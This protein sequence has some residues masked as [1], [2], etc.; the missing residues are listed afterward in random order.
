MA[1]CPNKNTAEYKALQ[2]VYKTELQTNNIINSW[3]DANNVDTFPTTVEAADYLR[4]KKL[5]FNLKQRSFSESILNNLRRERIIHQ[6]Q[7]K[8]Y[9][10]NSNPNTR[11]YDELILDTNKRKLE[12]Y[13]EIN[14]IPADRISLQRTPKSYKVNVNSDMFSEKDVLERSRSWDTPRARAVV[15]H[16][17][18][19]FPQISIEMLS[20]GEASAL[21]D[22]MPDWKKSNTPFDKINSFYVDGTAYLIKGRVTDETAIEEMLHPFVDAIAK[23]NVELFD[24]LLIEAVKNFPVMSQEISDSYNSNERN[25]SQMDRDLEIVT[26]ALSRHFNNE[27]ENQPTRSF[28]NVLKEALDWFMNII[29]N[30]NLYLTGRAIP[31][32]AINQNATFSDLARL[33]NTEGIQFKLESRVDGKIRFAL[34]PEKQ[35]VV[36]YAK[37]QA[38]GNPLQLSAINRLFNQ[39]ADPS[40]FEQDQLVV[41]LNDPELESPIVT[42]NEANHTYNNI[43]AGEQYMSATTAIKGTLDNLED[44][45]LNLDLGNDVDAILNAIAGGK[46]FSDVSGMKVLKTEEQVEV[47]WNNLTDALKYIVPTNAILLPQVILYDIGTKLAGTA[48]IV[49]VKENG[50]LMILD[51]KTTKNPLNKLSKSAFS[52]AEKAKGRGRVKL[53]DEN[54]KLS[55]D[56]LLKQRGVGA[57][58]TRGQHNLQV[59]MYRRM[60]QNMGYKVDA[61]SFGA[62]TLHFHADIT[63]KGKNQKFNGNITFDEWTQHELDDTPKGNLNKILPISNMLAQEKMAEASQNE[64]QSDF[65]GKNQKQENDP[66]GQSVDPLNYPETE[67]IISA[68]RDYRIGVIEKTKAIQMIKSKVFMNVSKKVKLEELASQQ[69]Y[70]TYALSDE[71]GSVG[72]S[73]IYTNL[74]RDALKQ[75]QEFTTYIEDPNNFGNTEFITSVVNFNRFIKTFEGLYSI[76]D[77][78]ELNNTQLKLIT[79]LQTELNKLGNENNGL[80]NEALMNFIKE[81]IRAR[82]NRD[83]GGKNSGFTEADLE[84]LLVY[85]PDITDLDYLT[86]DMAT[87]PDVILAVMDKIYKGAIQKMLDKISISKT[88]ILEKADKLLKLSPSQDPQVIHNF[89]IEEDGVTHVQKIGT[90]YTQKAQLL[91]DALSDNDGRPYHYADVPNVY[92]ASEDDIAKNIDLADKK[93]AMG[94]FWRA[95]EI[96]EEGNLVDGPLHRYTQAFKDARK[97]HEYSYID[98][99]NGYIVWKQRANTSQADYIQY[100]AKYFNSNENLRA[101]RIGGK[102]TGQTVFNESSFPKTEYREVR[103]DAVIDGQSILNPKYISIMNPTDALGS[104][105]KEYYE[106]W[107]DQYE[108]KLDQLP[109]GQRSNMLGRLPLVQNKLLS[110]AKSKDPFVTRMWAQTVENISMFTQG[111]A[112]QRGISTDELGNVVSTL[113][114]YFVGR[115]RVE[116]DLEKLQAEKI[117]IQDK[118]K[119]NKIKAK[120]YEKEIKL[121]NGKIARLRSTPTASQISRDLT[122]SLLKFSAM[123]QNYETMSTVEDTL[124]AMVKVLENREYGN[125]ETDIETTKSVE[126]VVKKAGQKISSNRLEANAVRRAKKFM[127]MV[128]YDNDKITKGMFDKVA[129]GL[130]QASSLTYVAFNPF[131]NFNNYVIGRVNNGIE[132]LGQRF[133]SRKAYKRA[134]IEFNK[135]A[136]PDLVS[137]TSYYV[138]DLTEVATLGMVKGANKTDYDPT[139]PNSK[140]EAFVDLFRMMDSMTDIREQG[141]DT[142]SGKSWFAKATEWGYVLQDAAEYNVQTKVGMAMLMDT[143]LKNTKEGHPEFGQ[144]LA[145]YDAFTYNSK[146]HKNELREGYDTVIKKNGQEVKYT[147]D[148]RY[149]LR[150]EIREVNKQ[151]HGNYAKEDRMVIQA[152]TLGNLAAQFHKWVMPAFRARYQ[153]EYFDENLGWMEGRYVSAIKFIGYVMKTA[154][155]KQKEFTTYK[156]GFLED[157]GFTGEGGNIDQRAT[158]KLFGFYRTA[159]EIGIIISVFLLSELMQVMLAGDDDDSE[160]TKRFKNILKYQADRTYKE[161]ILFTPHPSGLKQQYQM[162]KSPIAATRTLGEVGEALSLSFRTPIA[163]AYYSDKEFRENSAYVY[164]TK[165]RKGELKLAKNWKDVIPI[166]Y[167]IQKWDSYL[168]MSDFFIK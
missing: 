68:L 40:T 168:K 35:S 57:L 16:L 2:A 91:R 65:S 70:L 30:L 47:I 150:N 141:A 93:K 43:T 139:K 83:F 4:N 160:L 56:S 45:Q 147:D 50:D 32:N 7:D 79:T 29:E 108:Q 158:N 131:G 122:D 95:E 72:R 88:I 37:Q 80:V 96:D 20:V 75:I 97:L 39:T 44:V 149:Q 109:P 123:A 67:T 81:Q 114:V 8:Y 73:T 53:Y 1:R 36:D 140:Y 135:R 142:S 78:A 5:A 99:K 25:F 120:E 19:M 162:F 112:E 156:E 143:T 157:Q 98:Q 55:D 12:R 92:S 151:I 77:V 155:N 125:A 111:T 82:S 64:S 28:L 3:Q 61:S 62:T 106:M 116:G 124:N 94:D 6:Y 46:Q 129:D 167:S 107:I 42:F 101:V 105:Q 54:W 117:A 13:L 133:Y 17:K 130:I 113:P 121:I 31:V 90:V 24:K 152:T 15:M 126:G 137:R 87:S 71:V 138:G 18:R 144:T 104:A 148:F 164:Q 58:S 127:S 33:L 165:P 84:E 52:L 110:D 159:G 86:R 163:Y 60:L 103:D 26:Q 89:M 118:R 48:D 21:Y 115:P 69:A 22:S 136:I 85:A 11:E 100:K 76:K 23:D 34:T 146:T 63:G 119:V 27:Y 66:A 41:N 59:N 49:I 145:L 166:W 134:T 154:A 128:F 132:T 38:S 10:N 14:N 153:R 74:L 51:L 102:A 161:L 9:I